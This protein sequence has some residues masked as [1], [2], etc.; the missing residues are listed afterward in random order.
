MQATF[1]TQNTTRF[2]SRAAFA[3]TTTKQEKNIQ[4]ALQWPA[5]ELR[6]DSGWRQKVV[7]STSY[8]LTTT[9]AFLHGSCRFA[10]TTTTLKTPKQ[11]L[12][13]KS[14]RKHKAP[15]KLCT[16]CSYNYIETK[17]TNHK[18]DTTVRPAEVVSFR[19]QKKFLAKQESP[20]L[21]NPT[22]PGWKKEE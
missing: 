11:R 14:N 16:A 1:P 15:A 4:F 19:E 12:N 5:L 10:T 21:K 20:I 6:L 7:V 22:W 13:Q 18:E 17:N 3:T 9:L 8:N 2:G